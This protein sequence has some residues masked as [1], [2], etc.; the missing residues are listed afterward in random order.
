MKRFLGLRGQALNL[1]VGFIAG[2]DFLLFGYG[3]V[4]LKRLLND[5]ADCSSSDQGVMG[6]ILTLAEFLNT[7]PLIHPGDTGISSGE[8]SRRSTY[9]GFPLRHKFSHQQRSDKGL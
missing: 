4:L 8:Q 2:C 5:V 6:G 3:R 1:A 9:Q 7:F